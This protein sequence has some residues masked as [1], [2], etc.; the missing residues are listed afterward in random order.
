M[1]ELSHRERIEMALNHEEPDRVP[2]EFGG[3]NNTIYEKPFYWPISPKYGYSAL[4]RYLGFKDLSEP[5]ML[6]TNCVTLFDDRLLDRFGVDFVSY[7]MRAPRGEDKM[8][9][10]GTV[11]IAW[12]IKAKMVGYYWEI[13]DGPLRK[14]KITFKDIDNLE[15]P[16]PEDPVILEN[17]RNE[18]KEL[19]KKTDRAIVGVP[20]MAENIFH[21]YSYLRGFSQMFV[22]MKKNPELFRYLA[23][24]ILDI[25]GSIIEAFF[26]ECGDYIDFALLG[27]DMGTQQAPFVS[28]EEYKIYM[29]PYHKGLIDRV[30]NSRKI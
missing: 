9:D 7:T 29:K 10:D 2:I 17:V 15:T 6:P 1:G 28:P 14:P 23:N 11:I 13:F 3:V 20:T 5:Q 4:V 12:G 26:S 30:H 27:D 24:T 19:R 18:V 22:D 25:H 16:D 21:H 8:L